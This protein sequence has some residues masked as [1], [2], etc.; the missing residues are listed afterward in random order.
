M[1]L[2]LYER[3]LFTW[4]E[5]AEELSKQ[6]SIA[7]QGGDPDLGDTYYSHWL[8]A[9]ESIVIKKNLG[10]QAQLK[11]LYEAWNTAALSTPHGQSIEL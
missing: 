3:G 7:Q 4:T 10:E 5:W 6:I 1:T 8:S 11:K 9:L 2:A